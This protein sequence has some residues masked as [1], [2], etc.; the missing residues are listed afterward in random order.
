MNALVGR[1]LGIC[2]GNAV[3]TGGSR[4][5]AATRNDRLNNVGVGNGG[6]EGKLVDRI[7]TGQGKLVRNDANRNGKSLRHRRAE[8]RTESRTHGILNYLVGVSTWVQGVHG[9]SG[10]VSN[11]TVECE[12][13]F[14]RSFAVVNVRC[15]CRASN[16][17]GQGKLDAKK[18]LDY[19]IG[20]SPSIRVIRLGSG[21]VFVKGDSK[22][23]C[24]GQDIARVGGNTGCQS[25]I[26]EIGP[27]SAE[28]GKFR[29]GQHFTTGSTTGNAPR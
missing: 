24:R 10:R 27:S 25:S 3:Q 11:G 28:T 29:I 15:D 22:G 16:F 17:L 4:S 2:G 21:D 20:R 9:E 12:S 6:R 14:I 7:N 19:Q 18:V 1:A 13:H 5:G 8:T 23:G 26:V